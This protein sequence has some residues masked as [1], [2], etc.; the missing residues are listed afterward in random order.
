MAD[1]EH[2]NDKDLLFVSWTNRDGL[3]KELG[4]AFSNFFAYFDLGIE[5]FYSDRDLGSDWYHVLNENLQRAKF[6]VFCI[7]PKAVN[8]EWVNYELGSILNNRVPTCKA[9]K[10][11]VFPIQLSNTDRINRDKTPFAHN[12]VKKFCADELEKLIDSLLK[13][14]ISKNKIEADIALDKHT[15][16]NKIFE[17]AFEKLQKQ[18][19]NILAKEK[20]EEVKAEGSSEDKIIIEQLKADLAKRQSEVAN[21]SKLKT[22]NA[23]LKSE[24]IKLKHQI[25]VIQTPIQKP[26]YISV[27][28]VIQTPSYVSVTDQHPVIDLGFSD[29]LWADRNIGANSPID[30]GDYFAWGETKRKPTYSWNNYKYCKDGNNKKLMKYCNQSE[31]GCFDQKVILVPMDDVAFV[32]WGNGWRMP[33]IEEFAELI[34]NCVFKFVENYQGEASNGVFFKSKKNGQELFFPAA[35]FKVEKDTSLVGSYGDYWSSSLTLGYPFNARGLYFYS[36]RVGTDDN[37]RCYGFSVRPV[38]SKK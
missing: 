17:L 11:R 26:S 24:I 16:V 23:D 5:V 36:G 34:K 13:E 14:Y 19:E 18:V 3:G 38:R 4:E 32:Q 21:L 9:V 35:G 8:S 12:N 31:F 7:T 20:P 28:K 29:L 6:G 25:K 27:T 2:S 15:H 37:D 1:L 22:E 30:Y 33:T 10:K